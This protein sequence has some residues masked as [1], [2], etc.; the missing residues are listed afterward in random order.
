VTGLKAHTS[1]NSTEGHHGSESATKEVTGR[2]LRTEQNTGICIQWTGVVLEWSTGMEYWTE[3]LDWSAGFLSF[4]GVIYLC[5]VL[6]SM[7]I[8]N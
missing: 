1:P 8:T 7:C 3:V 6:L 4:S 5:T 2:E